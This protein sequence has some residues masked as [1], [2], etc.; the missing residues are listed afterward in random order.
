[1]K[2]VIYESSSHGGCYAYAKELLKAYLAHPE[3]SDCLLL[4][5]A[6]ANGVEGF[7]VR[8][9]LISD[10]KRYRISLANKIYFLGRTLINPFV[11][12]FFLLKQQPSL[13]ILNDFEQLSA[14]LWARLYKTFLSKHVFAIV[15]HDPDRDQYPPS[16]AFST[17][18][19][20]E[21]MS[22]MDIGL[23]HE[24]LP[25][26]TYYQNAHTK[27]VNIPHGVFK[28]LRS[29]DSFS[30]EIRN[31]IGDGCNSMSILGNIREE[32]NYHLAIESLTRFPSMKL[33]IAG[34]PANQNVNISFY[35]DL[36]FNLNVSERVI[37]IERFLTDSEMASLIQLSDIILLNYAKSFKSQSGI[38]NLVAPFKKRTI[39]SMGE[40]GLC[41]VVKEYALGTLVAPD[42][43]DSLIEGID[44]SLNSNHDKNW[45]LYL[46][47]ASWKN[48]VA[49][50]LN[51]YK[52]IENAGRRKL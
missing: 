48:H 37:W 39:V 27:F 41:N 8:K 42:D 51:T 10:N 22:V 18:S 4:L 33:I 49:I 50:V 11:L 7:Q 47:F 17:Y 19:M 13:V 40:S 23:Y 1:M 21:I 6:N 15:L 20:A 36:A 9:M 52:T 46:D 38:L 30:N 5:P 12:F 25:N 44:I 14:F 43:L 34:N 3:V 26:K 45:Q 32:K 24:I 16:K 31:L 28:P 35:K 2:V 29:K